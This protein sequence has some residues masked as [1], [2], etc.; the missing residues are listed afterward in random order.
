[1]AQLIILY[2]CDI[3]A[4]IIVKAGRKSAK[5]QLTNRFQEAI[6]M[7]AMKSKAHKAGTYLEEWRRSE[8]HECG[9]NL[10][11]EVSY[12]AQKIEKDYDDERLNALIKTGG[13]DYA[14]TK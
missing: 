14:S 11:A 10:E 9:E 1:M 3:P 7:A 5:Q 12:A 8:P 6:D 2:W 13:K 4:Q